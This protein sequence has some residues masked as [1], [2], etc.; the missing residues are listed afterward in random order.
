MVIASFMQSNYTKNKNERWNSLINSFFL[1]VVTI[2]GLEIQLCFNIFNRNLIIL[3]AFEFAT[4]EL[5]FVRSFF[6]SFIFNKNLVKII[7]RI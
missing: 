1:F 4:H 5:K 3:Y 6:L 7:P 2:T